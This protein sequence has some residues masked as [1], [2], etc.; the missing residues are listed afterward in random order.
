MPLSI[1]SAV[2]EN[3]R[4]IFKRTTRHPLHWT[5]SAPSER[6]LSGRSRKQARFLFDDFGWI[7]PRFCLAMI[8]RETRNQLL[9][10][11][12]FAGVTCLFQASA[13]LV[14][15]SVSPAGGL[16]RSPALVL[17]TNPNPTGAIFYTLDGSD[18][19]DSFGN[20]V[21]NA[22]SYSNPISVNRSTII[23]ARIHSGTNWSEPVAAPFTT[24][25]DLSKLLFTEIMYQP[26]DKD[27]FE[28]FV[29][30]KNVGQVPLDLSS[31]EFAGTNSNMVGDPGAFFAFAN[32]TVVNPGEFLV[33]VRDANAF[34]AAYPSVRIDGQ[35][36]DDLANNFDHLVIRST[37]GALAT[38]MFYNSHPPWPLVP[39]N[40]GYFP[41][42]GIGFSLARA[43]LNPAADAE[44]YRTWRA[45]AHRLG[46]PGED[47]PAPTVPP[48][49]INELLSRPGSGR[50]DSVEFFNPNP[51]NVHIGGWWLS[52]E[53]NDP[54][55]YLIPFGTF[56][57][58]FGFLIIDD[59]QFGEG[60]NG[61]GFASEGD[62]CFL[63]SGDT[64]GFLTGYSHGFLFWGGDRD[65]T[66]GRHAASDGSED[67]PSQ[68]TRT[69]GTTNSEPRLSPVVISE[70]MYHPDGTN[71]EYVELRNVT[72]VPIQ[73]WDPEAPTSTWG[74][75]GL[76]LP[77]DTFPTNTTIPAN[78]HAV[79]VRGD[80][81]V[82]R[83]VHSVPSDVPLFKLS[84][85]L[86][87]PW[88]GRRELRLFRPS[89][90]MNASLARYVEVDMVSYNNH[91]PWPLA[92]DGSG[93]SFERISLSGFGNDPS[94]W[95][96]C[97]I[98]SSPGRLNSTNLPPVVSA[99]GNQV[100]FVNRFTLLSGAVW[101]DHWP[102]TRLTSWWS[103][104]S[105]PAS[106]LFTNSM[107]HSVTGIFSTTGRYVLRLTVAD[108][109]Y[110]NTDHTTVDVITRPFDSWRTANFTSTESTNEAI[111]GLA[112]NP[113]GD[114][115]NNA[116]E[117]FFATP[118]KL[119]SVQ[120]PWSSDVVNGYFKFTWTQR[121]DAVDVTTTPEY[122]SRIE[123]PWFGGVG[124]FEW[125]EEGSAEDEGLKQVTVQSVISI[126]KHR[127]AFIRL[128]LS[129]AE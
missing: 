94:N 15:P 74:I 104:V 62:S 124:L 71:A 52:D 119:F 30:L 28:E 47:D 13:A 68:L 43:N 88:R 3:I 115:L 95:R 99:S 107:L 24:D 126:K 91:F 60:T 9:W 84:L 12:V 97:P 102:G 54:F 46:S 72:N 116:E 77:I 69:L 61:F 122:A 129:F 85:H 10:M 49:Y 86:N 29:E 113:D 120:R 55:G 87:E 38:T 1:D 11:V 34:Q 33:L 96:A 26:R 65:V 66:F 25:Q 20:V 53:R 114:A 21:T 92:A 6:T 110:T 106:V 8:L 83:T 75:G 79:F 44:H 111:S 64:N 4:D 2:Y 73:L 90:L 50:R 57:S 16:V 117:Y 5:F 36:I 45:S 67:F 98:I 41:D 118:P 121:I 101:D 100:G 40:H 35:Y 78:G 63:F 112:A 37:N 14:P 125:S 56:I 128:R 19:R 89:G 51:T 105:G 23:R 127:Q 59:T 58:A 108:G 103:Q 93:Y 123:G 17:V 39:D 32:G 48:I 70:V 80:T 22:R 27:D 82:F 76:G 18:P 7:R 42:D 81:N 31:L 109:V